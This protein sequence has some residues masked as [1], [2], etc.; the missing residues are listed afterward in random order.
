[1][2]EQLVSRSNPRIKLAASLDRSSQCRKKGRFL[3]EGPRF[4]EDMLSAALPLDFAILS[5]K[6]TGLCEETAYKALEK[7][8]D[9]L[10]VPP[11]VFAD[12][13]STEHSQGIAAVSPVPRFTPSVVF[14]GGTVLALD[15]VGDPG[16]AGTAIRSAAAFGCSGVLFLEGSV[17]P[18]N[19][20]VTRASAGLNSRVPIIEEKSL[21]VLKASF[22]GYTFLEASG[23]GGDIAALE[24]PP[25]V[26]IVIGSEADGVRMETRLLTDGAVSIPMVPGVDSLNAGVSASILLYSLFTKRR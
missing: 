6:A 19:P 26:C 4:I 16:N 8:I 17:Y 21:A 23:D 2:T 12:V 18:W 3:V 24:A 7:G 25:S 11:G 5:E 14:S 20:K 13:S 9:V 22:P 10:R 15:G 1:M